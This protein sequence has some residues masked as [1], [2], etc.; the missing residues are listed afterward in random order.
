M[1]STIWK[2]EFLKHHAQQSSFPSSALFCLRPLLAVCIFFTLDN[3][4][5]I[6][7]L[8]LV[9]SGP[10]EWNLIS[11][12]TARART[13]QW[14]PFLEVTAAF[15]GLMASKLSGL[16]LSANPK[17][18]IVRVFPTAGLLEAS[19]SAQHQQKFSPCPTFP[20]S[21]K[22]VNF[23][24]CLVREL[25][26]F[27]QAKA[28]ETSPP[29]SPSRN[30]Q[31]SATTHQGTTIIK[32]WLEPLPP[33]SCRKECLGSCQLYQLLRSWGLSPN[34]CKG[35][36]ILWEREAGMCG[37]QLVKATALAFK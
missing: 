15:L 27:H 20:A 26:A 8:K 1:N 13:D 18:V 33:L 22:L 4:S 29:S 30:M 6:S 3:N 17:I 35:L 21:Q 14:N 32:Q 25:W 12:C 37:I 16:V 2:P 23:S 11:S 19:T 7:H 5:F 24:Q 10:I 34:N 28:Q 31:T 36:F 9:K